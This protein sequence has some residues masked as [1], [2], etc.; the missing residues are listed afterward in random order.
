ML[1]I[2]VTVLAIIAPVSAYTALQATIDGKV[3][4][5]S[6]IT[7]TEA[8]SASQSALPSTCLGEYATLPTST[9]NYTF[10]TGGA[11]SFKFTGERLGQGIRIS[12]NETSPNG[13]GYTNKVMYISDCTG[14]TT[15]YPRSCY[16]SGT[17]SS[18]MVN[19]GGPSDQNYCGIEVGKPYYAVIF[20]SQGL[21][22]LP[23]PACPQGATCGFTLNTNRW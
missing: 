8:P 18:L 12:Y 9:G 20:D 19:V 3:Y 14:R 23:T 15:S 21:N 10:T 1:K 7:I 17:G 22:A 13:N 6:T 16:T 11:Y 4:Q 2:I 5:G